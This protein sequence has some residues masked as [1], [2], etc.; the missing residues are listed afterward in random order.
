[1]SSISL[2]ELKELAKKY[3]VSTTGS[4][5]TIAQTLN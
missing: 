5:A 2:S 4:K 1:M 3:S